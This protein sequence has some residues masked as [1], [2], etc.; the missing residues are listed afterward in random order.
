[1]HRRKLSFLALIT[2]IYNAE[3]YLNDDSISAWNVVLVDFSDAVAITI[4]LTARFFAETAE[5][6]STNAVTNESRNPNALFRNMCII[7]IYIFRYFRH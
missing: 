1:M 5:K 2:R 6:L 7:Y 3:R 4:I